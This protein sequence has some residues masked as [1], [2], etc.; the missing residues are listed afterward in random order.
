MIEPDDFG[1]SPIATLA[2]VG[3]PT[4]SIRHGSFWKTWN[5]G[6]LADTPR[7]TPRDYA[8]S[9]PS[10]PSAT[11]EFVSCRNVRIGCSLL[12]PRERPRAGVV[13]L[14]GY[15]NVPSLAQS[16]EDW[17]E[18][19]GRG[20]AVLI[21]RVRGYAGSCADVPQMVQHAGHHG[22]G[23]WI[24]HGL[25]IP[26]SD[27]G[28]GCDWSFSYG[29]ADV[30][31][32]CRALRTA[33]NAPISRAPIFMYGESFGGALA[34]IAASQL[35]ELEE[36]ARL[37]LG[38]PTLGDWPWRLSLPENVRGSSAGER[39]RRFIEDH[40]ALRGD[41]IT[42]LRVFDAAVHARR[43]TCPTLCKLATRDD[44]VPAP[45][46][47]AVFNALGSDPGLKWRFVTQYGH[48]DG[49]LTDLRRHALFTRVAADFLDPSREVSDAMAPWEVV[50][51]SGDGRQMKK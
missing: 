12:M 34:V 40:A 35:A 38:L 3:E 37:V 44:V 36:P 14:H 17:A 28:F 4:R 46:A 41:V 29:A 45:A 48:F 21:I 23:D 22:G 8:T 27:R 6:V 26:M 2:H 33:L 49:G 15:D 47:A 5:A 20:V 32:A 39:V 7:L 50:M 43:I 25:E 42:T 24:T 9:D 13:V 18:L 31:N 19:P 1:L 16:C 51:T 10:D 30:V 11:H